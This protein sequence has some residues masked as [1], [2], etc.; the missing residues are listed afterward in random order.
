MLQNATL[1]FLRSDQLLSGSVPR[2][3]HVK[4]PAT[5]SLRGNAKFITATAV[6]GS[7]IFGNEKY[8]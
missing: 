8:F 7:F 1:F 6:C 5:L 3:V 4:S 2:L